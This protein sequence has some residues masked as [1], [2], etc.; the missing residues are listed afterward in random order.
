MYS[1]LLFELEGGR[2]SKVDLTSLDHLLLIPVTLLIY[3]T[4]CLNE[5]ANCTK[6]FPSMFPVHP[7]T[8]SAV[9]DFGKLPFG[10]L[11]LVRQARHQNE[12]F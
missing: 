5:E 1:E 11:R 9:L 3:E 2:L 6:P 4:S 12:M 8:N 7:F 10:Y